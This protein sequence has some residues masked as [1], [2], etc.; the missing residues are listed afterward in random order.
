[1]RQYGIGNIYLNP[2]SAVAYTHE[3]RKAL[4]RRGIEP[5]DFETARSLARLSF[6]MRILF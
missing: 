6:H 2:M 4:K 3:E 5:I 1:M